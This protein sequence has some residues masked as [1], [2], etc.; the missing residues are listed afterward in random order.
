[1]ENETKSEAIPKV[2]YKS[3]SYRNRLEWLGGRAGF[4]GSEGKP[5][6]RVASPPEFKG[7]AGVWCPEDLFVASVNACVMA[8]FAVFL[9]RLKLPVISYSCQAEGLLEFADGKYRMTHVTLRPKVVVKSAE[10]VAP[11]EKALHD[12]HDNCIISNSI[13]STVVLEPE[14]SMQQE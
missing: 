14:I 1:V 4:L 7:E 12:A 8:T 3:F 9:D 2:K 11:T 5:G 13:S 10:A 6:F